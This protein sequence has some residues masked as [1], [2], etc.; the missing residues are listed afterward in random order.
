VRGAEES[1]KRPEYS[2][3]KMTLRKLSYTP[4]V[5]GKD[6]PKCGNCARWV[7]TEMECSIHEP[8][9]VVTEDLICNY[10]I[11]GVPTRTPAEREGM[12]PLRPEFSNLRNA[13]QVVCR[14]CAFYHP[15]TRDSGV[16]SAAVVDE[17]PYPHEVVD[18]YG[19]CTAWEER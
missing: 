10:H 6:A 18:A 15:R 13:G 14:A 4:P 1:A 8:S 19:H 12:V 7:L 5:P 11:Y 16:C 2:S 9:T 17:P 3:V